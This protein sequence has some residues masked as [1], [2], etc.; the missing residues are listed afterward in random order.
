M[1]PI[2]QE[3]QEAGMAKSEVASL[4]GCSVALVDDN[5][6]AAFTDEVERVLTEEHGAIVQRFLKP[7]GSSPSPISLIE[8]AAQCQLAV[9][10]IAL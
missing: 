7:W 6:H 9:V 5:F 1:I 3:S 10:G 4:Q 2:W 8:Q